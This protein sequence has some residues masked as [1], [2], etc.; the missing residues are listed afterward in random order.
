MRKQVI[1]ATTAI[2]L[3]IA[4]TG[5]IAFAEGLGLGGGGHIG[6]LGGG[7][8]IGGLG[9]G[10]HIGGLGSIGH[11]GGLAGGGHIG[12]LGGAGLGGLGVATGANNVG[13]FGIATDHTG[14]GDYAGLGVPRI[15]TDHTGLRGHGVA[16]GHAGFGHNRFESRRFGRG[17]Y[18]YHAGCELGSAWTYSGY[19]NPN[20]Y[21][22]GCYGY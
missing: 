5:T 13:R 11:V 18:A 22:S 7:G 12:S 15:E 1:A 21:P 4:T 19:C 17:F 8:H 3:G 16:M 10:G 9:G 6:G 20:C 14:I 2:V